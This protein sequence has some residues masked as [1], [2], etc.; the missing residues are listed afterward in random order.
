MTHTP[1]KTLIVVDSAPYGSIRCREALDMALALAAFDQPVS[2]LLR[3][4]AVNWLRPDQNPAGIEQK[5]LARNLGA[6][7]I[8]GV[9]HILAE[10]GSLEDYGIDPEAL[11]ESVTPVDA[12]ALAQAYAQASQVLQF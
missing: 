11:P 4:A 7:P 9:E 5:N 3:D 2:L 12:D 10:A 6:A 1:M 8:Y